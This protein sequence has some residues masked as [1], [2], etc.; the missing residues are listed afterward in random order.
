MAAKE[1]EEYFACGK[2]GERLFDRTSVT[3]ER[4]DGAEDDSTTA[5]TV[6]SRRKATWASASNACDSGCTSVFLS[7]AP[8]FAACG[9]GNEGR[10][11]CPKCSARVGNYSW[12]GA[13]C[14]CGKWVTPS[15]QFQLSRVDVKNSIV[16]PAQTMQQQ[17]ELLHTR[18]QFE[19]PQLQ[20]L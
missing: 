10:V 1:V 18:Q 11:T 5:A 7:E 4:G 9:E 3:H 17:Q 2:C 19:D 6:V 16:L 15:F 8:G 20:M 13:P 12:S 14:S